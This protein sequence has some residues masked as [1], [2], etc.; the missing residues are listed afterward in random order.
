MLDGFSLALD[1]GEIV[2]LL[3]ESGSGKST[4]LRAAAGIQRIDGGTIRINDE[5]VS[6]PGV[7]LPPDGAASA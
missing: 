7:H 5:V 4:I 6:G 3:G 2:C 1:P